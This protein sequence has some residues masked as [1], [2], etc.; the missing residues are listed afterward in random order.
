MRAQHLGHHEH[1]V[2]RRGAVRQGADQPDADHPRHRLVQ[3]LAEQDGL[4]LDATDPV[5]QHAQRV[6][7]RRVRVGPDQGVREGHPVADVDDGG[8][9]LQVDLVD[10][11]RPGRD[12]AQVAER[13]LGPAQELVALDVALV[14]AFHIEGERSGIAETVD[15]HG[16]VDDEIGRDERVDLGRVAAQ[17]GHRVAHDR[18][19]DDGRDTGQV[20]E[21]HT[22]RHER[23][24]GLGRDPGTP[25]REGL[26]VLGPDQPAAGVAQGVLEQDLDRDRGRREI[27]PVA[28]RGQPVVVRETGGE[29]TAGVE[30]IGC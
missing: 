8:Q 24:L 25:R 4:G 10:D 17:L 20:L 28:D 19:V 30:R 5:A 3:R 7:H 23:D 1:E 14:L 22:R 6:D 2:G 16:V 12:D 9:E 11:A 18:E 26:E 15:L 29:R 27:D 21:D 13:G